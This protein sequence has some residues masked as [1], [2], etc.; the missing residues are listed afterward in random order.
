M[1]DHH[2][3]TRPDMQANQ[4]DPDS[5]NEEEGYSIARYKVIDCEE[6]EE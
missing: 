2:V 3:G 5:E 4:I 1:L 6:R